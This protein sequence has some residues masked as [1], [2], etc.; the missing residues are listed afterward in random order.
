[1]T[2]ARIVEAILVRDTIGR[3]VEGDPVQPRLMLFTKSG[4]LLVIETALE[5]GNHTFGKLGLLAEDE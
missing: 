1:M 4:E 2:D 5:D 3:G